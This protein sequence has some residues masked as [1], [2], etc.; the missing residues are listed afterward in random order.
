[1][2]LWQKKALAS[3]GLLILTFHFCLLVLYA[4]PFGR[5]N[6]AADY[7]AGAWVYPYFHQ[8]WTLFT[9]APAANYTLLAC[10][11][12]TPATCDIFYEALGAHRNNRAGGHEAVLI[13]LSNSIDYFEK[14]TL[15]RQPLNGPVKED[16]MFDLLVYSATHYMQQK[17]GPFS[18][19]QL[20]L[21]VRD[22]YGQRVYYSA[23]KSPT[24]VAKR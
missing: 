24:S 21:I 23:R 22:K 3:G 8:S 4:N 14:N 17:H 5:G 9:P 13:A 19:L 6:T 10:T 15:L 11:N 18:R 20:F 16:L 2:R 7:L 12:G 1:M